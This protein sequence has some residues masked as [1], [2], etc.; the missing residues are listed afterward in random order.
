MLIKSGHSLDTTVQADGKI[1][2]VFEMPRTWA[3]AGWMDKA[4]LAGLSEWNLGLCDE[5]L[6]ALEPR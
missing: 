2:A 1:D 4:G 6:E 5:L 3:I